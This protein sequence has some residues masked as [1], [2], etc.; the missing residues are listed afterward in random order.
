[1]D[2]CCHISDC[3]VELNDKEKEIYEERCASEGQHCMLQTK[4]E[5]LA[6]G[7]LFTLW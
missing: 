1:M 4:Q 3:C 6:I 2:I 5:S 7:E